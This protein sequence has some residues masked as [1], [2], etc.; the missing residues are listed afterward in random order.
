QNTLIACAPRVVPNDSD[1]DGDTL[2]ALLVT[3]PSHGDLRLDA[4]GRFVY[5]P[6]TNF[7]GA[8]S[9]TYRANDGTLDSSVATARIT[10]IPV[11]APP[12]AND[13]A[14]T[15]TEDTTLTISAPGV[16]G[17]D[18]DPDGDRLTAILM[19][20][21][22]HGNLT[23]DLAGSFVYLPNTNFNGSDSFSYR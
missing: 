20:P 16:L 2:Q 12:V 23:L 1:P 4:T 6:N 3:P 17:N 18:V 5:V 9:F 8:D 19:T 7:S 13:D 11:N 15:L 14:F 21:P 10:I 22:A